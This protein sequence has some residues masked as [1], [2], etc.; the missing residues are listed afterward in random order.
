MLLCCIAQ[1]QLHHILL[2]RSFRMGYGKIPNQHRTYHHFHIN[3]PFSAPSDRIV[4][5]RLIGLIY[6]GALFHHTTR[7]DTTEQGKLLKGKVSCQIEVVTVRGSLDKLHF[8]L[9][10]IFFFWRKV[11]DCHR[12]WGFMNEK[13]NAHTL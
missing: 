1:P 11:N 6:V 8:T 7:T 10:C 12:T 13:V 3:C 2:R 9:T 5:S 4:R